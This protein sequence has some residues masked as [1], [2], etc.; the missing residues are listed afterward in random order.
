MDGTFRP[1]AQDQHLAGDGRPSRQVIVTDLD[2]DRD[3]DI[4]V[5]NQQP[6]HE[7]YINDR[8]WQYK[9]EVIDSNESEVYNPHNLWLVLTPESTKMYDAESIVIQFDYIASVKTRSSLSA[10]GLEGIVLMNLWGWFRSVCFVIWDV[11]EILFAFSGNWAPQP[12]DP[13]RVSRHTIFT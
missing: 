2:R 11:T 6:P 5:I 9:V 4:I 1:I 8:G 3:V 13:Q 12:V 10:Q 7:A